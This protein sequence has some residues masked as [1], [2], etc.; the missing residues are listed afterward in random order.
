MPRDMSAASIGDPISAGSVVHRA[1]GTARHR[2]RACGGASVIGAL[3]G[4]LSNKLEAD[5]PSMSESAVR[6]RAETRGYSIHKSRDRSIHGN[7]LGEY[8]L[9]DAERNA[10]ILGDRYNASLD[11]IADYLS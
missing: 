6:A 8:M 3:P 1:R 10:V 5:M 9:V 4:L 2:L 11:E 7:N